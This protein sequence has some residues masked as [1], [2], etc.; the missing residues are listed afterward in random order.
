MS[1]SLPRSKIIYLSDGA[2]TPVESFTPKSIS[3]LLVWHDTSDVGSM[4]LDGSNRCAQI[5]DKSGN[6][7]TS[8]QGVVTRQPVYQAIAGQNGL[9]FATNKVLGS[10]TNAA[11]NMQSFTACFVFRMNGAGGNLMNDSGGS[12]IYNANILSTR[13]RNFRFR[14]G[15]NAITTAHTEAV[16]VITNQTNRYFDWAFSRSGSDIVSSSKSG[17]GSELTYSSSVGMTVSA[18]NG[19]IFGAST[20][21]GGA[22]ITGGLLEWA[23]FN[24]QLT[25]DERTQLFNYFD[26]KWSIP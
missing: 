18:T 15:T 3:G 13:R 5:S 23:I 21:L 26:T 14:S 20:A 9:N 17:G 25:T 16:T 7:N 11:F 24:R 10:A 12:G 4:I 6:G 22:N 8:V 1:F 19:L 2:V